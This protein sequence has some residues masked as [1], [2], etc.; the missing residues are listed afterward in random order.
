MTRG[1]AKEQ[2]ARI[3][4]FWPSLP[5]TSQAVNEFVRALDGF[6]DAEIEGGI[7]DLIDTHLEP[8]APKLGHILAKVRAR[9][10]RSFST[11]TEEELDTIFSHERR[12]REQREQ[13]ALA[14]IESRVVE[15]PAMRASYEAHMESTLTN[16]KVIGTGFESTARKV[17]RPTVLRL[18]ERDFQ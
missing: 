14:A 9:R 15:S 10:P 1:F 12:Q 2:L 5:A 18:V 6:T 7:T 16:A 3:Q 17:F 8:G 11:A 4:A 13:D